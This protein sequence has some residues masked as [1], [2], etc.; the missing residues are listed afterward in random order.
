M[1]AT[2]SDALKDTSLHSSSSLWDELPVPFGT[3]EP[4]PAPNPAA[5]SPNPSGKDT[6][7]DANGIA[8]SENSLASSLRTQPTGEELV[9]NLWGDVPLP[10]NGKAKAKDEGGDKKTDAENPEGSKNGT[11]DAGNTAADNTAADGA[12]TDVEKPGLD[13]EN[14]AKTLMD[15]GWLGEVDEVQLMEDYQSE[16]GKPFELSEDSLQWMFKYQLDNTVEQRI[17]SIVSS[18]G[19]LGQMVFEEMFDRGGDPLTLL[20]LYRQQ[21]DAATLDPA[22]PEDAEQIVRMMHTRQGMD[23]SAIGEIITDLKDSA[24]LEK[25]AGRFKPQL[26]NA[27]RNE[28]ENHLRQKEADAA[29]NADNQQ[30]F[31]QQLQKVLTDS[32][33]Q[34]SLGGVPITDRKA[35]D[36]YQ[37]MRDASLRVNGQPATGFAAKLQEI[38]ADPARMSKL[39]Y[40]VMNDLNLETVEK[41]AA[42]R[43]NESIFSRLRQPNS[44][45]Q[46]KAE[47][48]RPRSLSESL[49]TKKR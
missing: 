6:D 18:R 20:Q 44:D 27:L 41:Q 25:T 31:D 1:V 15:H 29:R 24:L 32:I 9:S 2:L 12:K 19:K 7:A 23:A 35:S 10:E 38:Y 48:Q 8:P 40:L 43:A 5:A 17:E 30:R 28:K 46:P 36:L 34:K 11:K 45:S 13:F 49:W 14:I 21:V 4:D 42:S 37:F 26:D 33:K 3:N 47:P 22:K 16:T 39:A